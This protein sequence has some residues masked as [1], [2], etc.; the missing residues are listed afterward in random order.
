[1]YPKNNDVKTAYVC[2]TGD[3]K[4]ESK[5]GKNM[6]KNDCGCR[7]N[8]GLKSPST[9]K[10]KPKRMSDRD[11]NV[12]GSPAS[13]SSCSTCCKRS[14]ASSGERCLSTILKLDK[15]HNMFGMS[16]IAITGSKASRKILKKNEKPA[17]PQKTIVQ[18]C[19][20][21]KCSMSKTDLPMS[22]K[23][24]GCRS[25]CYEPVCSVCCSVPTIPCKV[26]CAPKCLPDPMNTG[27]YYHGM[28]IS[29]KRKQEF[30][31]SVIELTPRSSC[32][33]TKPLA[34][35]S[36]HHV[37]Q[38][39]PPSSCFPYL[40]PCYWPARP[41]APCSQPERCFHNPP[42]PKKRVKVRTKSVAELCPKNIPSV[43][44]E[45]QSRFG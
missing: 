28:K 45:I 39:I 38:C 34:A 3:L 16:N 1:M 5:S 9:S 15:E 41:G 22:L 10:S 23:C 17:F 18:V 24:G 40:M 7:H 36:C 14:A 33:L 19:C 4:P 11:P 42:C 25:C 31:P 30:K 26:P 6:A 29:F 44:D 20:S 35:R 32:V 37:P 8:C 43:R 13:F 27:G 2:L 12:C 21:R